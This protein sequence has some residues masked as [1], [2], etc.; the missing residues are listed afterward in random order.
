MSEEGVEA[1]QGIPQKTTIDSVP[2]LTQSELPVLVEKTLLEQC[3][4][5]P[6]LQEF[7]EKYQYVKNELIEK[8][9]YGFID[10]VIDAKSRSGAMIE[11]TNRDDLLATALTARDKLHPKLN[12]PKE[13]Q[14]SFEERM[15]SR[16]E[17][18]RRLESYTRAYADQTMDKKA[19][20]ALDVENQKVKQA[21]EGLRDENPIQKIRNYRER[22]RLNQKLKEIKVQMSAPEYIN[23]SISFEL[24]ILKYH[25]ELDI[26]QEF[27]KV[28]QEI[29]KGT[30]DFLV[31]LEGDDSLQSETNRAF[32]TTLV[33]PLLKAGV[34]KGLIQAKDR[35]EYMEL[36]APV[37]DTPDPEMLKKLVQT[38]PMGARS[39]RN[40][41]EYNY[42][43]G[44]DTKNKAFNILRAQLLK[45]PLT[46]ALGWMYPQSSTTQYVDR[47]SKAYFGED[48]P[49]KYFTDLLQAKE[50]VDKED[51]TYFSTLINTPT[52]K[53]VFGEAALTKMKEKAVQVPPNAD[54]AIDYAFYL[55]DAESVVSLA[56]GAFHHSADPTA[57]SKRFFS[58]LTYRP[59]WKTTVEKVSKR[60]PKFAKLAEV[61]DAHKSSDESVFKGSDGKDAVEELM[62]DFL[63]HRGAAPLQMLNEQ[64]EKA[65]NTEVFLK[66]LLQKEIATPEQAKAL[67]GDSPELFFLRNFINAGSFFKGTTSES[68]IKKLL[69]LASRATELIPYVNQSSTFESWNRLR[70]FALNPNVDK[71]TFE[72]GKNL[73]VSEPEFSKMRNGNWPFEHPETFMNREG[74]AFIKECA[75]VYK[76]TAFETTVSRLM[77]AINNRHL[78]FERVLELRN[79]LDEEGLKNASINPD[80]FLQTDDQIALYTIFRKGWEREEYKD[81]WRISI[82]ALQKTTEKD[83]KYICILPEKCS[84]LFN[85]QFKSLTK[86]L[87]NLAPHILK[88]E[89]DIQFVN[90]LVGLHGAK[91]EHLLRGYAECLQAGAVSGQDK[92]LLLEFSK[93]F[94]VF[95]PTIIVGH[96]KAKEEGR[97]TI[98]LAGLNSMAEKMLGNGSMTDEQRNYPYYQ[99]LLRHVY[100]NNAGGVWGSYESIATC[101]DQ[102]RDLEKYVIEPKYDIDLLTQGTMFLREGE[103]YSS[104]DEEKLWKPIIDG[105][106]R[107]DELS[108]KSLGS[109]LTSNYEFE[110]DV[111][112]ALNKMKEDEGK[113]TEF[114]P[115][116]LEEQVFQI[117]T[118]AMFANQKHLP[119][120]KR[121]LLDTILHKGGISEWNEHP[122]E[123]VKEQYSRLSRLNEFYIDTMKDDIREIVDKTLLDD[124]YDTY[125]KELFEE[126]N[127]KTQ[128]QKGADDYNRLQ[129]DKLGMSDSFLMQAG[130]ILERRYGRKLSTDEIKKIVGRYEAVTGGLKEAKSTS[131]NKTTQAFY[132]VLR[133]QRSKTL[134]ALKMVTGED[135]D[136]A[137][138]HLGNISLKEAI[139]TEKKIE[140]GEYNKEEFSRYLSQSM[141]DLFAPERGQVALNLSKF[142]SDSGTQ[143]KVLRGY[144]TKTKESA[145]ARMVGGVCVG[146]DNPGSYNQ[147][148]IWGME[149]YSQLVFQNPDTLV[150]QGLVLMHDYT[151]QG[152]RVL[153]VSLNP[154][155]TYIQASDERALFKGIMGT[156]QKFATDNNFDMIASST[157]RN[158]RTNR[159]GGIFESAL[160]DRVNEVH[161]KFRFEEQK[162]FSYYPSYQIQDMDVLW[163]NQEEK[164]NDGTGITN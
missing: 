130:K 4:E 107:L 97:E 13:E 68:E 99:G 77:G 131:E 154:S 73:I 95:E 79:K 14:L 71:T 41:W 47:L 65:N 142:E 116:T 85:D 149:E 56:I 126:L 29:V 163:E 110:E 28:V 57:D 120:A 48:L 88:S 87:L 33:D 86:T 8:R 112:A 70:I 115:L 19:A 91:T 17:V 96:K 129:P 82:D 104:E 164:A 22:E 64:I 40:L 15:K 159:T 24:D 127:H 1:Q 2:T 151:D 158:I 90:Q 81:L 43:K 78:T 23:Y 27:P 113:F 50:T 139:A 39:T 136:P 75:K 137:R 135:V 121:I 140:K 25:Q 69:I 55:Q 83:R 141:I 16:T 125:S 34:E 35:D 63:I 6:K 92:K 72:Y 105:Q 100:P 144:I 74:V 93:S 21:L 11:Y 51:I 123:D 145:H 106:K 45:D 160:N 76:G 114:P 108:K 31:G 94:R 10:A 9:L 36:I 122:S 102:S 162:R 20:V 101:R 38:T 49:K 111:Q 156:L 134:E 26:E 52:I 157:D 7:Q 98:F 147:N 61:I 80:L 30:E 59:D 53:K 37:V 109:G 5:N 132:G 119:E 66:A 84:W 54:S 118:N 161:K 150:C 62:A 3:P 32:V 124:S 12:Y 152:K 117:V 42:S 67:S 103:T 148:S 46:S 146:A 143:R 155:E 58:A 18:V 60:F 89:E 153:C 133:N 44:K 138:V 128:L